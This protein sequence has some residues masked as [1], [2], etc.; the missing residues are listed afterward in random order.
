MSNQLLE[1]L[2]QMMKNALDVEV[3]NGLFQA[4]QTDFTNHDLPYLRKHWSKDSKFVWVITPNGTHLARV[5]V[6]K[7]GNNWASAALD[8]SYSKSAVYIID[9]QKLI[10]STRDKAMPLSKQLNYI[11]EANGA[12][13]H[14]GESI[15]VIAMTQRFESGVGWKHS[16]KID[17]LNNKVTKESVSLLYE[18]GVG[19]VE[20]KAGTFFISFDSITI[21]GKSLEDVLAG[22]ETTASALEPEPAFA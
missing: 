10:K 16:L 19:E 15:A 9:G 5:G 21:N 18:I 11:V 13:K 20:K 17:T 2:I 12:V 14:K 4:Y 7:S 22:F 8:N 1:V 3:K 6:S